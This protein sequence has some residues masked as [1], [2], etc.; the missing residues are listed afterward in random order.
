MTV[1]DVTNLR[2]AVIESKSTTLVT[3]ELRTSSGQ[4]GTRVSCKCILSIRILSTFH[5]NYEVRF[6]YREYDDGYSAYLFLA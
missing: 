6:F 3:T 1:L 2:F 4:T 5:P